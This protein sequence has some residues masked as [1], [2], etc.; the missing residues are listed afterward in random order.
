[1]PVSPP[2]HFPWLT[3]Q[4]C[5]E[6]HFSDGCNIKRGRWYGGVATRPVGQEAN[7][8]GTALVNL[9]C[10]GLV[11]IPG[12]NGAR[13]LTDGIYQNSQGEYGRHSD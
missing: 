9:Q 10:F 11:G 4:Q 8:G 6:K 5:S 2:S 1:M 3:D 13:S 12:L 7:V